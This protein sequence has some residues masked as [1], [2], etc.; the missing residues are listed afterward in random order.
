MSDETKKCPYCAETIKAEA[1]VCRYCGRDL[2]VPFSRPS[3]D[4]I[5]KPKTEKAAESEETMF[6]E[7]G[8]VKITNLRAVIGTKTYTMPN[9]TSVSMQEYE[10][11]KRP[12]TT[13]AVIGE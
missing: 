12:G 10:P 6:L 13:L 7:L 4:S 9:V 3:A 11:N 2:D 8:D 5:K 1:I